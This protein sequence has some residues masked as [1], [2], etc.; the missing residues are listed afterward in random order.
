MGIKYDAEFASDLKANSQRYIQSVLSTL[1]E[2]GGSLK[3]TESR[4]YHL[5][6][7]S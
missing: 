6:D 2:K 3:S 4:K 7:T 5:E 1:G